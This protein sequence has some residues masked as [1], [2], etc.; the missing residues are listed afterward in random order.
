MDYGR[1]KGDSRSNI[2]EV[3]DGRRD[4]RRKSATKAVPWVYHPP[5]AELSSG[6]VKHR[7]AW[8]AA[9]LNLMVVGWMRWYFGNVYVSGGKFGR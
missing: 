7:Y 6:F 4:G 1:Q 8:L 2:R 5:K 9:V 3:T